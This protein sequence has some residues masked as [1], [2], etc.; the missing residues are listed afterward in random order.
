MFILSYFHRAPMK[1]YLHEHLTHKYLNQVHAS[2]RPVHTWFLKIDSVQIAGMCVC[3]HACVFV[4]KLL[5][6]SGVM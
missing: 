4:L 1:I 6:T 5:I 3:V 2:D